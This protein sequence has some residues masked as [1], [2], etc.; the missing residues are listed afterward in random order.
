MGRYFGRQPRYSQA[1]AEAQAKAALD[2]AV[3]KGRPPDE[4]WKALGS[5][6]GEIN[7]ELAA[8]PPVDLPS[9][10]PRR[11]AAGTGNTA[12]IGRP[13]A[14]NEI[15]RPRPASAPEPAPEPAAPRLPKGATAPSPPPAPRPRKAAAA[16]PT[17]KRATAAPAKRAA[18]AQPSAGTPSKRSTGT[19]GKAAPAP[20]KRPAA[21]KRP[22]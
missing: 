9:P 3:N 14:I 20:A 19:T 17:A 22:G 15:L 5:R 18:K 2:A 7:R 12:G 1:E 11:P 8:R 6:M 21:K 13:R 10:P 4:E 16:A